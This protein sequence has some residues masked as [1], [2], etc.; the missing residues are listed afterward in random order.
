MASL[1]PCTLVGEHVELVPL[2]TDHAKALLRAGMGV[3]WS[4][5]AAALDTAENMEKWMAA[6]RDAEEKG[7][8]FAFIVKLR[9]G[10]GLPPPED[11]SGVIGSTRYMDI[12]AQHR[13][14]EVGATWY[15]PRYQGTVVNPECKYLLLA[16]AF[17]DWGAIRVQIKTDVKNLRSQHAIV[18][19]GAKFE[20]QLRNHRMRRDGTLR[21]S[22]IYSVTREEWPEVKAQLTKR[23]ESWK[24]GRRVA[25]L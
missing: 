14:V 13:G 22:M 10:S 7:E 1:G 8:E 19:L 21:D 20:G 23:I 3:D 6:T 12:Q 5:M 9:P 2:E 11:G 24:P 25:A 17:E 16:H 4:W 18:K 15:S